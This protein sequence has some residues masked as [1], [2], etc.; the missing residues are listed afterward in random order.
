MGLFSKLGRGLMDAG[1]STALALEP[2]AAYGALGAFGGAAV[3]DRLGGADTGQN[4]MMGGAMGAAFGARGL[5]RE[6]VSAVARALKQAHPEIPDEQI[7][8]QAMEI[9][10]RRGAD[11]RMQNFLVPKNRD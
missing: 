6:I 9:V 10:Q 4:A 1:G 7:I 8:Q 11:G 3:G 5:P 2:A